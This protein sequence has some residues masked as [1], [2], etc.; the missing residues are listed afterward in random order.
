MN[1]KDFA[2]FINSL[3]LLLAIDPKISSEIR[4]AT[5]WNWND[6]NN[7]WNSVFSS[8]AISS[9]SKILFHVLKSSMGNKR[10]MDCIYW[11]NY[12]GDW[13]VNI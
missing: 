3:Y 10:T 6:A 1:Q 7:F 2:H 5:N 4:K 8:R 11:S 13:I 12:F 9:W